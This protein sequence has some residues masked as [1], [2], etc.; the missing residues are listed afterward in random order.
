[1]LLEFAF[2]VLLLALGVSIVLAYRSEVR[3]QRLRAF[4]ET[5]IGAL[6]GDRD[7]VIFVSVQGTQCLMTRSRIRSMLRGARVY[8]H[9]E[10]RWA[11]RWYAAAVALFLIVIV[12]Y[13]LSS[14][15]FVTGGARW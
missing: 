11:L 9:R 4:R 12:T 2:S 14:S 8:Q 15:F 7:A 3:R 5:L 1:M 10:G 13:A 6:R